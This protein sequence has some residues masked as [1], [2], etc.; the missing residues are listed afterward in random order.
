MDY[1][2]EEV[3]GTVLGDLGEEVIKVP[4]VYPCGTVSIS[5]LGLFSSIASS[6]K[7]SRPYFPLSL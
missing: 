4:V 1:D 7:P 5:S 3:E 2:E 6:S